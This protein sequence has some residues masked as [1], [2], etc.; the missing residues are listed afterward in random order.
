MFKLQHLDHVAITVRDLKRSEQWYKE[1]LGLE[2]RNPEWNPPVMVC[3]GPSCVALF[4]AESASPGG[5]SGANTIATRHFAFAVDRTGFEAIQDEFKGKG[6]DFSFSDHGAGHS[7]YI[8]D[9]DGH[10][11]EIT[12]HELN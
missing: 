4:P 11:I 2:R 12:T 8:K 7:I 5:P 3:A 10:T 6:I 9:P 1:T